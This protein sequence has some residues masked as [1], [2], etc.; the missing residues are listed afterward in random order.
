MEGTDD[1]RTSLNDKEVYW[2]SGDRVA[3]F[4][5][6]TL[7]K[8]F[9]LSSESIGTKEGIF[10]YDP[11]YI[12]TG[13]NVAISNNVAYYPFTEVTCTDNGST[14]TLGNIILPST[15]NYAPASFGQGVFPMVAVTNN[16]DDLDFAF[17]NICGVLAFQFKGSGTI[18]SITVKGNSDEILSGK[19]TVTASYGKTPEIAL[20]S[21][22]SKTVTLDCGEP[23]VSLQSNAPTSFY[24]VLP[25]VSFDNGFTA[26]VT[27]ASGA[28][29]EYSTTK[30]NV[31]HR[32]GILRMPEKDYAEERVSQEGDYID[33]YGINQGSGTEIDGVVWAP[34]NCGYHKDYFKY[35][36]LYQ[37]GRKYGQ[38]YQGDIYDVNCNLIGT[39]SDALVSIVK[40]GPVS[41]S[42]GQA[43]SNANYFYTSNSSYDFDWLSCPDKELWNLGT[44]SE[45]IKT[46]YDPCPEGWRVPTKAELNNLTSHKSPWTTN[47]GQ[48][49]YWFSGSESYSSSVSS[50]FFPAAGFSIYYG[51][52]PSNRGD[53]GHYWS[54]CPNK[55]NR[56][57][58]L[59]FY[60]NR[61]TWFYDGRAN[62]FSV[63]CVKDN[64]ELVPVESI[65]LSQTTL[66]I[67]SGSS[68][69]LIA[70]IAPYDANHH[71]ALW[72][73]ADESIAAVNQDGIV[74]A[75]S[76]GVTTITAMAGMQIATCEVTVIAKPLTTNYIDEY[77]IDQG[78]GVMIGETTWA[79]VNC[80]YHK[81]DF[82]Y[83]KLY[84]WGRKYGQ[85]YDGELYDGDRNYIGEYSDL[86]VLELVKGPVPLSTGQSKDNDD[87]FYYNSSSPF[88]WCSP[89]NDNLWNSGTEEN[90]V[91][92]EYDPCPE[93]WRVPTYAELDELKNNY[94]SW[95]TDEEGQT[96][97]WF[98]G[99][100]S[101]SVVVPQVF[102]P[103][104]G[105]RDSY[106]KALNRGYYGAYWSS[107]PSD[108]AYSLYFGKRGTSMHNDGRV[109]GYSVRCVQA[110]DKVAEL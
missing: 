8:R 25:P 35:G 109:R 66:S 38:G 90:P 27:D 92:T 98:S 9:D 3:V 80:G 23:G 15:Q 39:Y 68:E 48:V 51:K 17:K 65:E 7:R 13:K 47:D 60:N 22:G 36:K 41:L 71:S 102:F 89:Q 67:Y 101:Y 45:P 1:T 30:K 69:T 40:S 54:S 55:N 33:E 52:E 79:P 95:T 72:W 84:Q 107:R 53:D 73:A 81:A 20:L 74:T 91:K 63:R 37:W 76:S 85:G 32:S 103:A 46:E 108:R 64:S 12:T 50:V 100:N 94:S 88:D 49:G 24:I 11:D 62:G 96:G 93:G 56:A 57:D 99:L 21:D 82:K 4:M 10:V 78:P 83:G 5:R 18:K 29:M 87:I 70:N 104:A 105:Y 59:Y 106:G 28:T 14:Y 77:G 110:T 75:V 2:S 58:Y 61:K 6:N 26:T 86:S 34:V 43:Q 44:E 31:I 97:L 16:T 19:A 42:T